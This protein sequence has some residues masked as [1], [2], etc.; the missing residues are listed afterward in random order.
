[1]DDLSCDYIIIKEDE[2]CVLWSFIR[3]KIRSLS[4]TLEDF[5][6]CNYYDY[7]IDNN[8]QILSSIEQRLHKKLFDCED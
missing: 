3:L 6:S 7:N 8:Y 5:K 1:M 2:F 4:D